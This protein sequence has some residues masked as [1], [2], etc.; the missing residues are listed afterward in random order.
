MCL[1]G[2]AGF[3]LP[4][5]VG[6]GP[7]AYPVFKTTVD[8]HRLSVPLSLFDQHPLQIVRPRGWFYDVAVE[9]DEKGGYTALLLQCTHQENQLTPDGNGFHCNLHGSQFDKE[10]R[11]RKGPAERPLI[12]Y[13]TFTDDHTLFI[14]VPK[15][16]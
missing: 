4:Q 11:V 7:G 14:E 9:K 12:R 15:A 5:L 3:M 2:A 1:L 16:P 10:G 8:N 6:C 13:K